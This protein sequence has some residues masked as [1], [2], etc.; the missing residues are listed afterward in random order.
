MHATIYLIK[1]GKDLIKAIFG[2]ID[3][4]HPENGGAIFQEYIPKIGLFTRNFPETYPENAGSVE[5]VIEWGF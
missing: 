1:Q 4:N 2:K 3:V 5:V